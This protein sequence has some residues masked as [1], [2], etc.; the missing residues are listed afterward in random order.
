MDIRSLEPTLIWWFL[1]GGSVMALCWRAAAALGILR[2]V[3]M[4]AAGASPPVCD[5]AGVNVFDASHLP[6][7][8]ENLPFAGYKDFG[9]LERCQN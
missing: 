6:A 2:I 4:N 8:W 1:A 5:R 9:A 3:S 7:G